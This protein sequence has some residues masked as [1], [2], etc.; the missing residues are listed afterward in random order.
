MIIFDIIYK[1][2][3]GIMINLDTYVNL[4]NK[5]SEIF[6]LT[7]KEKSSVLIELKTK[8]DEIWNLR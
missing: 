7:K 8:K 6:Q 5:I 1:K 4:L 2:I 3:G